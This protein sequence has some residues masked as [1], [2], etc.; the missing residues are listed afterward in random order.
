MTCN[1]PAAGGCCLL[2]RLLLDRFL[3][4]DEPAPELPP[5]RATMARLLDMQLAA[6]LEGGGACCPWGLGGG[7]F[8]FC[9]LLVLL[10]SSEGPLVWAVQENCR[11]DCCCC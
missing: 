11:S 6:W 10:F 2:L 5:A 8:L 4:G 3:T 7:L 9:L 1:S